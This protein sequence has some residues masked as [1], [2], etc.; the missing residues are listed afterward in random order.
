MKRTQSGITLIG[1]I[2]VL[3]VV[4][5]FVYMGIKVVPMY[6]EFF[7][8]K[9]ALSQLSEEPGITRE[10]PARIK[11]LFFRRL[12]IS[13]ADSVKKNNVNV[14]RRDAGFLVTVNYEVRRPLISNID[15]VGRFNA[16]QSLSRSE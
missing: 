5:V 14:L 10:D 2:V 13:Y 9:K 7:A 4:G 8:V 11:E 16:E 15:V 3:A 12:D 6:T 1:F